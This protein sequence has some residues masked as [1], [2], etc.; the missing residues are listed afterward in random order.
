ML[1]GQKPHIGIFGR[2]NIGKSSIIN[3]LTGQEISI[4]SPHPG[5]TTDPVTKTMEITGIGPVVLT[6]T[7]GIDDEGD[8]GKKRVARSF[9]AIDTVDLGIIAVSHNAFG[10]H[11]RRV[12]DS[13]RHRQIPFF[14]VHNKSDLEPLDDET[15]AD[16]EAETRTDVI[17]FNSRAPDNLEDVVD[18]IKKHLPP[19]SYQKHSILGDMV[20]PG[21]LVVLVTPVDIE[22]PE[23]RI[24]LPQ[25]QTIRDL[26]DNNC[27]SVVLRETEL[28]AYISA[29]RPRPKL[30]V[31]DSQAL[32]KVDAEVPREIPI[33]SFSILYTRLKGDYARAAE[34]TPAISRLRDGDRVMILESCTHHVAG[35]DI[36]RVKLP[37]WIKRFTGKDLEFDVVA[38]LDAPPRPMRDYS[39][40]IQCGGCMLTRR[41]VLLRLAPAIDAGVP[42]TN[43]G[44][45]IAWCTG[46][47]ERATAPFSGLA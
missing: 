16:I 40:V 9:R 43:Y 1:K 39:L 27:I 25:V 15:K 14:V 34:G 6:D 36:G 11:E 13:L 8:L 22:T 2:R 35:D 41:Q 10:E 23:G 29:C 42:V 31:T 28:E 19:T 18:L 33:T 12:A 20:S 4:V 47:F 30:V 26:L 44:M 5:T 37:R 24:I 38:G 7:A 46:T 32:A 3:S 21:D 45:A 17:P